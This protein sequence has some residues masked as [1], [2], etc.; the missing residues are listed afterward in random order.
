MWE[1]RLKLLF[2]LA[3]SRNFDVTYT[4]TGPSVGFIGLILRSNYC[5]C[6]KRI[7]E[8]VKCREK[9]EETERRFTMPD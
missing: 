6:T 7:I 9:R 5:L 4:L 2:F 1:R 8:K 3:S